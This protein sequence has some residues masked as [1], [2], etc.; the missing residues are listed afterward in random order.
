MLSIGDSPT[1]LAQCRAPPM[2]DT[3]RTAPTVVEP[4]RTSG[5]LPE[6]KTSAT[7]KAAYSKVFLILPLQSHRASINVKLTLS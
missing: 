1:P 3:A 7:A 5:A 4:F 2:F 6:P